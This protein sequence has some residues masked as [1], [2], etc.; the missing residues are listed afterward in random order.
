MF[1]EEGATI[2]KYCPNNLALKMHDT[3]NSCRLILTTFQ[4]RKKIRKEIYHSKGK[5]LQDKKIAQAEIK[6]ITFVSKLNNYFHI[7]DSLEC[8]LHDILQ[9][10]G[11]ARKN[12]CLIN[13]TLYA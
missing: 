7:L 10:A 3:K 5:K 11:K 6:C 1:T 13:S 9:K 12:M 2:V 8:P 4:K